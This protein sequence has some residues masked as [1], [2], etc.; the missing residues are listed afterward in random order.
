M[1]RSYD[2]YNAQRVQGVRAGEWELKTNPEHDQLKFSTWPQRQG[3]S[4]RFG[5][6]LNLIPT[7]LERTATPAGSSITIERWKTLDRWKHIA[8]ITCRQRPDPPTYLYPPLWQ[9]MRQTISESLSLSQTIK[10]P[11][12]THGRTDWPQARAGSA[13]GQNRFAGQRELK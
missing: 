10:I 5:P 11:I 7:I 4:I 8:F 2:Y 9:R 13:T 12:R 3:D 6:H 1:G